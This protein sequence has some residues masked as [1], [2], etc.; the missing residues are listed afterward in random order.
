MRL[1][2]LLLHLRLLLL[3]LRLLLLHPRLYLRLLLLHLRL[4]LLYLWLLLLYLRLLP[5]CE[6]LRLHW[7]RLLHMLFCRDRH[8]LLLLLLALLLCR[9]SSLLSHLCRV[10]SLAC[11]RHTLERKSWLLR[12]RLQLRRSVVQTVT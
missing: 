4:H 8:G 3:H 12:G 10:G 1:L 9:D 2:P 5:T 6:R 11:D 7:L